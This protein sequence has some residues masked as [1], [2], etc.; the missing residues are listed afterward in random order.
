MAHMHS[1]GPLLI[2]HCYWLLL[3]LQLHP[4]LVEKDLATNAYAL[5][6]PS[7]VYCNTHYLGLPLKMVWKFQ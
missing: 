7:L 2:M 4:F 6:T 5:V 1:L 3:V